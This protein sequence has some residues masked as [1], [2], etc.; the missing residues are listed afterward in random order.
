MNSYRHF[1][2]G[3]AAHYDKVFL[4]D[5]GRA[6][7][8][9]DLD[10][11]TARYAAFFQGLGLVP[12]DRVAAQVDK[13]A[14]AVFLYLGVLRAGL[15]YLPLNTD[16]QKGELGYF[17]GDAEPRAVVCRG[18]VEPAFRELLKDKP[19]TVLLT[20]DATGEG[21][22]PSRVKTVPAAAAEAF[23]TVDREQDDLA[24]II[25]TSGTTGRSKGAMV[26]H[27]NIASNALVLRD[28]WRITAKDVLVHALPLFHVHGLFVAL[29][30]LMLSGATILMQR[31]FDPK[32][33]LA[34]FTR[35]TMLMGVPTF[36][37]R[38]LGE[39]G[40]TRDACKGMRL[41]I[42][43][44]AP[45]LPDT[46]DDFR[47]RSGHTILERYGMSEAGMITSNPYEGER[48]RGT[49]GP[50]LPGNSV[51]VVG[52]DGQPL[53]AG[54]PGGVEIRGPNVFKGYWR[55]PEK[56]K[57]EF[58]ADGWFRTGDIG[59]FDTDGY[60]AIV[61]RA[62]DLIISGG[63]NVYP[64][65]VELVLDAIPGVVESA[66]VGLPHP[67]FGEAVTAV[68]AVG[69]D[70]TLTEAEVIAKVKGELAGYKVPKRV[71]FVADLPRNAMGKVQ[72]AELRKTLA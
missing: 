47:A 43:G 11:E 66:V 16:Y 34:E 53:P 19:D 63:Y 44:S 70:C 20:L 49:V 35:A 13:S 12:G 17:I 68:L 28:F 4:E 50:A 59:Q 61:G 69:K 38:L 51:R 29:H 45:L 24:L 10:R 39:A 71:H 8:F 22:L 36:Y 31:K 54:E 32:A 27:G 1:A 15:A 3:F 48:K 60:L 37:V 14:E 42:S 18:S 56:T 30:P 5:T 57:E 52:G 2:D 67:D 40:L 25:Y 62:K 58:T 64:K 7:T 65:E 26:T 46:F 55:M 72:K 21:T 33:V 23:R 6:F 9:A 41:F